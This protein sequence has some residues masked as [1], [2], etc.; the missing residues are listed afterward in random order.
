MIA[1]PS[2]TPEAAQ[3]PSKALRSHSCVLC[4]QRKVRCDRQ[5]PCSNCVKTRAECVPSFPTAPRRRRRKAS[6]QDMVTKMRRYERLLKKHGVKLD[7]DDIGE[8]AH[9]GAHG[10]KGCPKGS[11]GLMLTDRHHSRYIEK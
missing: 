5:N 11:R 2:Q 10:S 7:E 6:E 1:S 4:Q 9:H 8:E 3:S